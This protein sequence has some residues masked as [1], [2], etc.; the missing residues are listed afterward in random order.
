MRDASRIHFGHQGSHEDTEGGMRGRC[1]RVG[2]VPGLVV[3]DGQCSLRNS[4]SILEYGEVHI[5]LEQTEEARW[6]LGSCIL[7]VGLPNGAAPMKHCAREAL[8]PH[9]MKLT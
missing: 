4:F 6:D 9:G 3:D 5:A 2:N 7:Y 8:L 1:K